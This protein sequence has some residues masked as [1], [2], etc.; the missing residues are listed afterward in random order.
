VSKRIEPMVHHP[1]TGLVT[2]EMPRMLPVQGHFSG[3]SSLASKIVS[4]KPRAWHQFGRRCPI[5]AAPDPGTCTRCHVN[6]PNSFFFSPKLRPWHWL[7]S[8]AHC[9]K[10]SVTHTEFSPA[11]SVPRLNSLCYCFRTLLLLLYKT[12][13]RRLHFIHRQSIPTA[14]H[15]GARCI[16]W[17]K[18]SCHHR[19][20]PRRTSTRP[21]WGSRSRPSR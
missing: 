4:G 8:H 17:T 14:L 5:P 21:S 7:F 1:A 11:F 3:C 2:L 12:S 20:S 13:C 6:N 19:H 16:N 10:G 18:Q 9:H 15:A